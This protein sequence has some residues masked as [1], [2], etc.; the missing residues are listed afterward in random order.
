MAILKS[1][2]TWLSSVLWG[3]TPPYKLKMK[4]P[5]PK[6]IL[7]CD[8]DGTLYAG[9]GPKAEALYL[10]FKEFFPDKVNEGNKAYV[11]QSFFDHGGK[12]TEEI[13]AGTAK[14][15]GIDIQGKLPHMTEVQLKNEKAL[16][17]KK[18]KFYPDVDALRKLHGMGIAVGVTTGGEHE[19]VNNAVEREGKM[20]VF[21]FVFGR[22]HGLEKEGTPFRKGGPH[23]EIVKK[24]LG[25]NMPPVFYYGD[26]HADLDTAKSMGAQMVFMREGTITKK[27]ILEGARE[28]G[29][30][31]KVFVVKDNHEVVRLLKHL[32]EH[33]FTPGKYPPDDSDDSKKT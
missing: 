19:V 8:F 11:M 4:P 20:G 9:M 33:M 5:A 31:G 7:F 27:K 13:L 18:G 21:S 26:T 28:K 30:E 15:L 10:T 6:A 14:R 17:D 1:T 12:S 16:Y 3:K 22:H 32:S 25:K 24:H 29:L 23:L 2:F